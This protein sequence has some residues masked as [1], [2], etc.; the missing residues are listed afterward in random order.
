[1]L[2]DKADVRYV[3]TTGRDRLTSQMRFQRQDDT[4]RHWHLKETAQLTAKLTEK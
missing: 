4:H 1:V 3:K 2:A